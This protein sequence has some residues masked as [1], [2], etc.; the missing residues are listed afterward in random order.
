MNCIIQNMI[1]KNLLLDYPE[2]IFCSYCIYNMSSNKFLTINDYSKQR[3]INDVAKLNKD[4]AK[5]ELSI[6]NHNEELQAK[7]DKLKVLKDELETL[8]KLQKYL[9]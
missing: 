4:I 9:Q 8:E 7:N 5:V 2:I 6:K 1:S 3:L